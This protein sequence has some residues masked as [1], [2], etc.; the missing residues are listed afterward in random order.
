M[1]KRIVL[2]LFTLVVLARP[3]AATTLTFE[4]QPDSFGAG[5]FPTTYAGVTWT[6]WLHYAPYEANGYDPDGANAIYAAKDGA[7]FSFSD[8]VFEGASFSYPYLYNGFY[9]GSQVFFELYLDGVAVHT[10]G[11]LNSDQLSFLS[12]GYSGLVDE[13]IVRNVG[14][15]AMTGGGSAW[16]MDNVTFNGASSVPDTGSTFSLLGASLAAVALLR[17][18]YR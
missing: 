3:A 18:R 1:T 15:G 9:S 7:K 10:S 5:L 12:S 16:I 6:D 2:A 4:D 17:R 14:G 8:R 13:V 11:I